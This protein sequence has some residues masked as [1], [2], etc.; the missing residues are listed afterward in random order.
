LYTGDMGYLEHFERPG[1][2]AYT[3]SSVLTLRQGDFKKRAYRSFKTSIRNGAPYIINYDILL[4]DRVM[5]EQ[6]GIKYVDQVSAIKYEYD[7]QKPITYT[8]SVG[9]D[10]KDND[11]FAQGI[12]ALQ[13]V[14]TLVGAVMGQGSIFD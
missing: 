10:A 2:S 1:G 4:D 5:F 11:P 7:R 9:D 6:D 14:Y 12:R 8:V 3:I 13:A